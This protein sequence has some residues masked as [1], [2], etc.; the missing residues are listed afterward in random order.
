MAQFTMYQPITTDNLH[1]AFVSQYVKDNR[2]NMPDYGRKAT[3]EKAMNA[4]RDF[5]RPQPYNT[6][7]ELI[8]SS[9]GQEACGCVEDDPDFDGFI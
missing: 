2:K 8:F 6:H 9:Y 3:S 7:D 5:S 4:E 1:A